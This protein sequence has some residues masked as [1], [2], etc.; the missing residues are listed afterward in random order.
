MT[1]MF[2]LLNPHL[3]GYMPNG[4]AIIT[5]PMKIDF[6]LISMACPVCCDDIYAPSSHLFSFTTKP[7]TALE[8]RN[9]ISPNLV[10]IHAMKV[11]FKVIQILLF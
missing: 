7:F 3:L 6:H 11:S 4:Q 1:V 5:R 10:Q 9:H 2:C 8:S